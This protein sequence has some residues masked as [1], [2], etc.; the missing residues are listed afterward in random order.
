MKYIRALKDKSARHIMLG[1]AFFSLLLLLVIGVSLFF[2]ALP[3]MKEKSLW[4]L[5]VIRKLETI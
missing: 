1:I 3:I 4:V 5:A 2:K